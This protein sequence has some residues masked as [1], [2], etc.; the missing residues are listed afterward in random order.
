MPLRKSA[1]FFFNEH[2]DWDTAPEND[3]CMITLAKSGAARHNVINAESQN[4]MSVCNGGLVLSGKVV[5]QNISD[6][7]TGMPDVTIQVSIYQSFCGLVH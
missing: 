4:D 6:L 7:H 2:T 3:V 1:F 5:E